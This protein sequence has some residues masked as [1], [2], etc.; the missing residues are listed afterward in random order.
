MYVNVYVFACVKQIYLIDMCTYVHIYIFLIMFVNKFV[1]LKMR[2]QLLTPLNYAIY[3]T[4]RISCCKYMYVCIHVDL[5]TKKFIGI[6]MS[7]DIQK[8]K[9][10]WRIDLTPNGQPGRASGE[11]QTTA[12]SS[13]LHQVTAYCVRSRLSLIR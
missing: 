13:A 8:I 4:G 9:I 10:P 7:F 6:K 3:S 11:L 1:R 2:K 5:Q 12:R